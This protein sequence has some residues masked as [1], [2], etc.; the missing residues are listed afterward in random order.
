MNISRNL[1][2]AGMGSLMLMA[3]MG[4]NDEPDTPVSD[5]P[6]E[7]T[8]ERLDEAGERTGE[9][10]DRAADKTGEKVEEA[11]RKMQD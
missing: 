2:T 7:R 9:A 5:G 1:I 3:F 6:M 4:C 8:G 11:G 10:V